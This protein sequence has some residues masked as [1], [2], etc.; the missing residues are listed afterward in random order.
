MGNAPVVTLGTYAHVFEDLD[1][2]DRVSAADAIRTARDALDGRAMY[3]E[4]EADEDELL[5]TPYE[6]WKPTRGLEPRTPSLRVKCST[7]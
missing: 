1:P 7:S 3:A 2:S 5:E 6:S 4:A